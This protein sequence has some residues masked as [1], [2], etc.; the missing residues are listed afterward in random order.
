MQ[1][2]QKQLNEL[3]TMKYRTQEQQ[4]LY[5]QS[6]LLLQKLMQSGTKT[7]KNSRNTQNQV[8]VRNFLFLFVTEFK[9][10]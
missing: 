7:A 6:H 10:C 4:K 5:Q 2:L 8:Q 9:R 3:A 1:K